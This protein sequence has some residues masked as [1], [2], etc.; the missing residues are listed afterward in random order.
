LKERTLPAGFI[1]PC[2]PTKALEPPP[3]GAWLHEIKHDVSASSPARRVTKCGYIAAP[4]TI[5]RTAS[6]W[7]WKL[8]PSYARAPVSSMVK[9]ATSDD[10]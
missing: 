5:S 3:G 1:A 9:P 7:S 8:W 6:R 2:L 4:A 10:T